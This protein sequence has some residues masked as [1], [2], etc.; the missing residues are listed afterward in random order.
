MLG[1]NRGVRKKGYSGR[2]SKQGDKKGRASIPWRFGGWMVVAP[3]TQSSPALPSG[4]VSV[5][6]VHSAK[7]PTSPR[8]PSRAIT[9]TVMVRKFAER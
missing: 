5:F 6:H 2:P 1:R 9:T 3:S 8:H 4:T 7:T